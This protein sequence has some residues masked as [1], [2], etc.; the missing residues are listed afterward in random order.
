[1]IHL[2]FSNCVFCFHAIYYTTDKYWSKHLSI[3]VSTAKC[4]AN[5]DFYNANIIIT[6]SNQIEKH[7]ITT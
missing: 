5:I 2:L 4:K 1:M 7:I 3:E 6:L